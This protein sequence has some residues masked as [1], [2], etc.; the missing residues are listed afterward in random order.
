MS[1][2]DTFDSPW[3]EMIERYLPDFLG[4]FFPLVAAD[5][6]W[7]RGYVFRDTEL[8]QVTQDAEFGKRLAD[9]LVQ[10]WTHGGIEAWVL[11]HI[12][13]Q[14]QRDGN[15]A[16]RMFVYHYRLFDRYRRGIVSLAVLS[17]EQPGWR[18]SGYG[19][20][21]W[22]CALQFTFPVV[23]L[24]DY[25]GRE[26]ELAANTN[27]FTIVVLAHLA[28]QTTRKDD[29]ARYA[30][31]WA[32]IRQLYERGYSREQVID[33]F[34]AIDWL[35]RLPPALNNALWT[36][37]YEA[38]RRQQMRYITSV[39][40][41]G[42]ERG[43]EQGIEQGIERVQAVALDAVALAVELRFGIDAADSIVAALRSADLAAVQRVSA[44]TRT[45]SSAAELF[46]A[47]APPDS[48][49]GSLSTDSHR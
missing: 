10:V 14:G 31:K 16:E 13:V 26:A 37:I 28:T 33:V 49:A 25:F 8:Q 32:L 19:Y 15:F 47:V 4:F 36:D 20:E 46:L 2:N 11:I 29:Q 38:E 23:K 42:I 24:V 18:P 6:D 45:A 22:G 5:L 30:A 17:D 48:Q 1:T 7:S 43:I 21:Q 39:E 34:S 40:Q 12:E 3:K 41:I 27:P 35:L 44:A 9:R